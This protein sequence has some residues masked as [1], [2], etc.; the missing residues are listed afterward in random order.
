MFAATNDD[1]MTA[2]FIKTFT[3]SY[4]GKSEVVW[5][6]GGFHN[7]RESKDLYRDRILSWLA[8]EIK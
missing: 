3:T 2:E 7:G 6:E 5:V 1:L 4:A 8:K